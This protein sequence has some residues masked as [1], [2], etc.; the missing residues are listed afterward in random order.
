[1]AFCPLRLRAIRMNRLC[2][3]CEMGVAVRSTSTAWPSLAPQPGLE[4]GGGSWSAGVRVPVEA[5]DC[6]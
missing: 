4:L 6:M 3:P 1:M 5:R 2:R